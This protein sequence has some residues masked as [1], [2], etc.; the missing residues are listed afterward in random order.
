MIDL[1]P[2]FAPTWPGRPPGMSSGDRYLWRRFLAAHAGLYDQFYYNVRLY[3]HDESVSIS[4]PE[5]QAAWRALDAHRI[6]ALGVR[7]GVVEII[8]CRL[9][10][11]PGA[12]GSLLTYQ[13][14]W[15]MH[16]EPP[17][18]GSPVAVLVTD[19][20]GRDDLLVARRFG[21]KVFVL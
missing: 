9:G 15:L 19:R 16:D 12:L 10:A 5:L 13:T 17:V 1:G 8:E 14:I 2:S 21:V 11:G 7:D 18:P 20:I 6:D 4:S 3:L